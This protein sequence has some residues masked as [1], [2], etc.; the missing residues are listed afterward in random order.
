MRKKTLA[1]LVFI[2][3]AF[4]P[5]KGNLQPF[6]KLQLPYDATGIRSILQD[7]TGM[8]WIGTSRGLFSYNGYN[9]YRDN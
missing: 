8:M 3:L 2:L 5:M 6:Q 1:L 7:E 9:L 4:L